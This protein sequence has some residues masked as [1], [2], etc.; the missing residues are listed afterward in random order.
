MLGI[1]NELAIDAASAYS[2]LLGVLTMDELRARE[3]EPAARDEPS[4]A[5]TGV[6]VPSADPATLARSGDAPPYDPAFRSAVKSGRLTVREAVARGEREAFLSSLVARHGISQAAAGD[7]ADNRT[8]LKRALAA[9]PPAV[10]PTVAIARSRGGFSSLLLA[11]VAFA[12][13]GVGALWGTARFERSFAA[14]PREPSRAARAAA[15]TAAQPTVPAAEPRVVAATAEPRS[16]TTVQRDG[17]GR[18]VEIRG[19]SPA[20]VLAAFCEAS[21]GEPLRSPLEITETSPRLA[22]ARLGLFRDTALPEVVQA[23]WMRRDHRSGRWV[24]GDGRNAIPTK[25][26]AAVRPVEQVDQAWASYDSRSSTGSD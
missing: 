21:A 2:L 26:V 20:T 3:S 12:A 6:A 13:L 10:K 9:R 4:K 14:P 1:A 23:I 22:H 24:A 8:S 11:S 15:R 5:L 18:V 19:P 25:S 17:E 7:V 16:L